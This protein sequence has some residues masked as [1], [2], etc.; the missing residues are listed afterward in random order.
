MARVQYTTYKF[1]SPDLISEDE[2]NSLK[3]LI[4]HNPNHNPFKGKIAE[5]IKR[6]IYFYIIGAPVSFLCVGL[7]D[8]ISF[9]WISTIF[10]IIGGIIALML[11][12]GLSSVIP[13]IFS[14]L[15]YL[16]K[17]K[18]YFNKLRRSIKKST[19]Y[20]EFVKMMT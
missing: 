13:T 4:T 10:Y 1:T 11:F 3:D 2:Y 18:L 20:N 8:T 17:R 7:G 9:E 5:E 14:Y 19:D 16:T 6:F 15:G 12:G